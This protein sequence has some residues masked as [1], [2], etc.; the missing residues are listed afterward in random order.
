MTRASGTP[1]PPS[2]LAPI[3]SD[4]SAMRR[5]TPCGQERSLVIEPETILSLIGKEARWRL[6]ADDTAQT[7]ETFKSLGGGQP[8]NPEIGRGGR[9]RITRID[10]TWTVAGFRRRGRVKRVRHNACYRSAADTANATSYAASANRYDLTDV[11]TIR[12]SRFCDQRKLWYKM[13]G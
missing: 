9:V 11:P 10:K 3:D 8:F 1:C 7:R 5:M 4:M 12:R 13:V 6:P 2:K